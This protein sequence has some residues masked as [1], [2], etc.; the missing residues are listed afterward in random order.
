[1]KA[2]KRLRHF[3]HYKSYGD[4]SRHPRAAISAVRD[5]IWPNVKLIRDFMVVLITCKVE[6]PIKMK[7]LE[8]SQDYMLIFQK[9]KG[10]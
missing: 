2:L 1:M 4:F 8:W 5:K 3:S 9:L 7:A 10:R 6:D